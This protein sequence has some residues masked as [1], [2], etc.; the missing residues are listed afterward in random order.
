MGLV[1]AAEPFHVQQAVAAAKAAW[2]AWRATPARDRA[3]DLRFA[4]S[5]MRDRFFEL[6]AWEV[7]E[8]GKGWREATADVNEAIDFCEYYAAGEELLERP[9]GAD[10]PGEVNRFEYHRTA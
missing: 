7:Y 4:A 3:D 9:Q 8:C 5:R 6:A 1:S 2:P 10:V